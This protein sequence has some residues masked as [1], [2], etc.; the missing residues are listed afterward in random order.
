MALISLI[1]ALAVELILTSDK[2]LGKGHGMMAGS[3]FHQLQHIALRKAVCEIAL[4][5]GCYHFQLTTICSQLIS[6]LLQP[7]LQYAPILAKV[8]LFQ[9]KFN[10]PTAY[11]FINSAL[12]SLS[13]NPEMSNKRL[14]N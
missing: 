4:A 11:N 9:K 3:S 14:P 10:Q 5:I 12:F 8:Q 13:G 7:S 6:L 2:P 1:A